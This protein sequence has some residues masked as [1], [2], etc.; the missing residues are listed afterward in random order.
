MKNKTVAIIGGSQEK[1]FKQ[2][3]KKMGCDIL[4]HDGLSRKGKTNKEFLSIINKADCVVILVGACSHIAMD[5]V[6]ALCKKY[7]VKLK[8]HGKGGS[9][10]IALALSAV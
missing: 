6:K 8:F 1:T 10:A 9:G 3:G 4:F 2:L 7:N 5:T